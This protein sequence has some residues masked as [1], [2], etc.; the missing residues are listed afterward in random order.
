MIQFDAEG[1]AAEIFEVHLPSSPYPGLRP[2]QKSEWPIFVGRESLT[3][4]V[5]SLLLKQ[6]LLVVHGTS[7]NGKSSLIRAG[8]LAQLEQEHARSGIRWRTCATTPGNNP[9]T[10]IAKSLASVATSSGENWIEFRRALNHGGLGAKSISRLLNLDGN[11]R[12]C[13]L[14]DQFEET[15]HGPKEILSDQTKLLSDFLVGFNDAPP[16]GLFVLITMRS[17]FLGLCSRFPGLAETINRTQYLLPR[18]DIENLL[19]AVREPATLYGGNVTEQFA[20]KLV[21]DARS[22]EDELPLIQHGLSQLW[23]AAASTG[24]GPILDISGYPTSSYLAR[25]ISDHADRVMH[26]LVGKDPAEGTVV[27]ELFRALTA[28]NSEGYAI[29]RPRSF[30]ELVVVTGATESRLREILEAFR[31]PGVSF[32]TPYPP[33]NITADTV[34]DIS[35]E[36]LIRH[37]KRISDPQAG[38]LQREFRDG[39]IWQALRVQAESFLSDPRNLLSEATTE[40]RSGWLK[41]RKPAWAARYGG[42]WIEVEQLIDASRQEIQRRK[43]QDK[44][45]GEHD[46]KVRIQLERGA[47]MRNYMGIAIIAAIAMTALTLF[48]V[49]NWRSASYQTKIAESA[50]TDEKAARQRAEDEKLR[51][52]AE[53]SSADNARQKAEEEKQRAETEKSNADS[54]R[55]EAI[56]ARQRAED[57]KERAENEKANAQVARSE[58]VAARGKAEEERASAENA[59]QQAEAA[60][61]ATLTERN[62]AS[63]F[64]DESAGSY[65]LSHG[66]NRDTLARALASLDKET[67]PLRV[68]FF[69][70]IVGQLST[71]ASASEIQSAMQTLILNLEH[72]TDP[73][74]ASAIAQALSGLA[75]NLTQEQSQLEAGILL[76][77][78][79][80]AI[81]EGKANAFALVFAAMAPKVSEEMAAEMKTFLVRSLVTAKDPSLVSAIAVGLSSLSWVPTTPESEAVI[82]P[83]LRT[84][85]LT[86]DPVQLGNIATMIVTLAPKLGHQAAQNAEDTIRTFSSQQPEVF[87]AALN[88]LSMRVDQ[89]S[90][91]S[92]QTAQ[93]SDLLQKISANRWCTSSRSYSLQLAGNTV[94]W[95]DNLGSVDTEA[96]VSNNVS[97]AQTTTQRSVHTDGNSEAIGTTWYYRPSGADRIFVRSSGNKSFFLKRC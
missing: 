5:I 30:A 40:S 85:S 18:M 38:W 56:A 28:I 43:Q 50:R 20:E 64:Q 84:L 54:A 16:D 49:Y 24:K 74:S 53:R 41:G 62:R 27:E 89:N 75:N 3:D 83:I 8:V 78:T 86:K 73:S 90:L 39:L 14:I 21:I 22:S 7:G 46:E 32:I 2:F 67:D 36:A 19:R 68:A 25:L 1:D 15:F 93:S 51:A 77:S 48:A 79:V 91:G 58:A 10:N 13:L 87:K 72:T 95:R 44:E 88:A 11:T 57:E 66:S 4:A 82:E 97:E 29:R 81:S 33:T 59:R 71:L 42:M 52:E 37:W 65:V 60:L 96:I 31:Q 80:E 17:E 70:Q 55:S 45:Q 26:I 92:S 34:V 6:R 47:R 12:V 23:A 69:G 94:I 76:K 63:K 9:L 61:Q 35:H